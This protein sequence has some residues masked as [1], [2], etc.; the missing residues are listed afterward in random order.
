L[1]TSICGHS[2]EACRAAF[3]DQSSLNRFRP[4]R[5]DSRFYRLAVSPALLARQWGRIGTAARLR[6]YPDSGATIN[7]LA[8]L[9]RAK[10]SRGHRDSPA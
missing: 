4:A 7:A 1:A 8:R 10:R 2:E 3:P 5:N 9:A 6:P